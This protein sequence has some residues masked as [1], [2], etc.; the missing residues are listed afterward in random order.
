[1]RNLY[2]LQLPPPDV[3]IGP[4][5]TAE[6]PRRS[7]SG[8]RLTT[9]ANVLNG[10]P[11][12]STESL[13]ARWE[14]V[15]AVAVLDR[16]YDTEFLANEVRAL[17]AGPW[18]TRRA[19]ISTGLS[20]IL[21]LR[22]PGGDPSR[23][24]PGGAGP[25]D[26]AD[27]PFLARAPRLARLLR[28]LPTTLLAA[29]LVAL[30][31]KIELKEHRDVKCGPPWGLVRLHIPIITNPA[32][33]MVID[34]HEYHWDAGR[35]WYGDF[36]R[37]H[38]ARNSGDDTRIHLVLDCLL[39]PDLLNLFPPEFR[40]SLPLNDIL[41]ARPARAA[42]WPPRLRFRM[43]AAFAEWSLEEPASPPD[44]TVLAELTPGRDGPVLRLDGQPAFGLVHLGDNEYRFTGW[45]E[46]RTVKLESR[47]VVCRVRLGTSVRET[48]CLAERSGA[49]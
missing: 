7:R 24:D 20:T 39:S 33:V 22:S 44:A 6:Y 38:Q 4:R 13:T 18:N 41:L 47:H 49:S 16:D 45:S 43:P 2:S 5:L 31:P 42:P 28:G 36:N 21:P 27:T 11:P 17:R 9:D 12:M 14:S 10:A 25:V 30:A 8:P 15:P 19:D 40:E 26:H 48:I 3:P 1:M 34:G 29:H 32:A 37:P 46:E 35:L 23:T